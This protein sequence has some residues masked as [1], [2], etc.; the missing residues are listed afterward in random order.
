[1]NRKKTVFITAI[2]TLSSV[3]LV[4][5]SCGGNG[6]GS[7]IEFGPG[8]YGGIYLIQPSLYDPPTKV[9]TAVFTFRA[10]GRFFFRLDTVFI[11]NDTLIDKDSSFC[12]VSGDYNFVPYTDSIIINITDIYVQT[13]GQDEEPTDEYRHYVTGNVIVLMGKEARLHRRIELWGIQ[14]T[15]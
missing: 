4:L 6:T 13:C 11:D 15:P 1:V 7:R 3:A 5:F 8:I 10:D 12:E 14:Q 2:I 9:D